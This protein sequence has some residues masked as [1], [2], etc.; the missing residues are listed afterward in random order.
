[1]ADSPPSPQLDD[2][3]TAA[4]TLFNEYVHADRERQRRERRI[5]KAE[6]AKDEAA[7]AVRKLEESGAGLLQK[8][9]DVEVDIDLGSDLEGLGQD[10]GTAPQPAVQRI[11]AESAHEKIHAVIAVDRIFAPR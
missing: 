4:L 1:M 6:K 10:D 9:S 2:E 11:E 7:A 5:A 8:G 3:T